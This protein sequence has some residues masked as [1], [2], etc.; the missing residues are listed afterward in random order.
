M[1]LLIQ[2]EYR[3]S[4]KE[5]FGTLLRRIH[6]GL[7]Q[8]S[9]PVSFEFS[10]ADSPMAGGVSSVNRAVK[11]FPQLVALITTEPLPENMG[12]PAGM[13]R[14]QQTISGDETQLPFATVAEVADGLPR[15]FPFN[16]ASVRFSNA[17]FGSTPSGLTTPHLE[18]LRCGISAS[19][20]WWVNGRTRF[21]AA[22]YVV[23]VPQTSR[24]VPLPEGPL[25]VLLGI[26]GKPRGVSQFP[27]KE[28]PEAET[29]ALRRASAVPPELA[30]LD[31]RIRARLPELIAGAR[32]PHE[33][34]SAQA[35]SAMSPLKPA[36]VK[37]FKPMGYSCKGGS[38][39]F[40][41]RRRTPNNHVVEVDLDVGTWSRNLKALFRVHVP[42][43]QLTLP[44][45]AAPGLKTFQCA[46][47]DAGRWEMIVENLA[48]LTAHL[49]REVV[50]EIS[51]AAGPA[52]EWFDAPD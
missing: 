3:A 8:T 30:E 4:K 38:G 31:Q 26:L 16:T 32:M 39:T 43:F 7:L 34:A 47:G 28:S 50:P 25:G 11:K 5:P 37:H 21:L 46:I 18:S 36:L 41:L 52:P 27:I 22:N 17:A 23:D 45:P 42:D 49:D 40:T 33:I 51:A 1:K 20:S 9:L 13:L 19:D 15:S 35:P 44:M 12:A 48:A 2:H 24:K 6:D 29:I 14:G 10:F